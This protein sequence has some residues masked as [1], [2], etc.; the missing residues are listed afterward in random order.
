MLGKFGVM[1]AMMIKDSLRSFSFFVSNLQLDV[2]DKNSHCILQKG[3][4]SSFEGHCPNNFSGGMLS[5]QPFQ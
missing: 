1:H 3:V 4:F 5:R 2:N